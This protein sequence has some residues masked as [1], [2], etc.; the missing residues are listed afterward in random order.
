MA[1]LNYGK[2]ISSVTEGQIAEISAFLSGHKFQNYG[3]FKLWKSYIKRKMVDT[4]GKTAEISAFLS[5]HKFQNYGFFK[6]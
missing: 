2:I 4:G 6:L 5:G 1:F 3:F